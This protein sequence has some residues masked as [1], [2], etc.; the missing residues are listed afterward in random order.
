MSMHLYTMSLKCQN[1]DLL[2][3]SKILKWTVLH[4]RSQ[5]S[6]SY[7]MVMLSDTWWWLTASCWPQCQS[8]L[9]LHS[10]SGQ[11]SGCVQPSGWGLDKILWFSHTTRTRTQSTFSHM[12][13]FDH[14]TWSW[15]MCHSPAV[16][17]RW[18]H[19][20]RPDISIKSPTVLFV[21]VQPLEDCNALLYL[22]SDWI[23]DLLDMNH[24][25]WEYCN[26]SRL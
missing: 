11:I 19:G 14:Y 1:W 7:L 23:W 6:Q 5:Q 25:T 22:L 20:Y 10:P 13:H 9:S 12:L 3:E 16:S 18:L 17:V 24:A 15:S 4:R 21:N 8:L 2:N 26:S